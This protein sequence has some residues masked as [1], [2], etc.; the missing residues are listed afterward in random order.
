MLTANQEYTLQDLARRMID[1]SNNWATNRLIDF[2]GMDEI[3]DE[4]DELGLSRIRLRRYMTGTGAPSAHGNDDSGDDYAEGFDNTA[5][6]RQFA[7]FLRQ[8]DENDDLLTQGSWNVFWNTLGLNSGA[9]GGILGA[10]VGSGWGTLAE[11]A[12]SNTWSSTPDHR[13]QIGAHLQRSAAGRM[14]LSNGETV[15]YAAFVDEA[16]GYDEDDPSNPNVTPLQ[17]MLSCVVMQAAREYS[18][19]TTG[20]DVGACRAG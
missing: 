18:G 10:G 20:N 7:A 14:T 5:S 16:D 6:P 19:Q 4:L 3:N 13:P 15:V 12:G 1:F 17:N 9:H 8:M 2:V 11:K